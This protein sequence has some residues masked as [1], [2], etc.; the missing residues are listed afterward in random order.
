MIQYAAVTTLET[1]SH[2]QLWPSPVVTPQT[3][4]ATWN[5]MSPGARDE[6]SAKNAL[7]KGTAE[8]LNI[9]LAALSNGLLGWAYFPSG[10]LLL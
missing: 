6:M 4:N 3:N 2:L 10:K 8:A 1:I 9:Y 5:A 7:R